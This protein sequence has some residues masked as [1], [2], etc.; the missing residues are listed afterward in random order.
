[1]LNR[2]RWEMAS[3]LVPTHRGTLRVACL[4]HGALW[5]RPRPARRSMDRVPVVYHSAAFPPR[6]PCRPRGPVCG[7]ALDVP[8]R[9][10]APVQAST[11]PTRPLADRTHARRPR[12]TLPGLS[13]HDPVLPGFD[14]SCLSGGVY[15]QCSGIWLIWLAF[16]NMLAFG[17]IA[18]I[19]RYS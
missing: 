13:A 16:F 14:L 7:A 19:V 1:M 12:C 18:H 4:P 3:I 6:S 2:L 8:R 15:L 5:T 10:P 11:A 17:F 9:R